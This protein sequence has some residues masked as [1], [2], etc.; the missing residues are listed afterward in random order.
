MAWGFVGPGDQTEFVIPDLGTTG[1][2]TYLPAKVSSAEL[3]LEVIADGGLDF[4]A[5][6]SQEDLFSWSFLRYQRAKQQS[7]SVYCKVQSGVYY[8]SH[9]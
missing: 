4:D 3:T 9:E 5:L 2:A 1:N 7:P 8:D 6:R